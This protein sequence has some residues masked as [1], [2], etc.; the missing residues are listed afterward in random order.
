MLTNESISRK[1]IKNG[2][3]LNP[4]FAFSFIWLFLLIIH[5]FNFN[6]K[7]PPATVELTVFSLF[8]SFTSFVIGI[9]YNIHIREK[10][11]GLAVDDRPTFKLMIVSVLIFIAAVIHARSVPIISVLRGNVEA[12]QNFG[13]TTLTPI[14]YCCSVTVIVISAVKFFYGEKNKWKNLLNIGI[15]FLTF[16]LVY[17]RGLIILSGLIVVIIGASKYRFSFKSIVFL[18]VL[19]IIGMLGFNAFGNIRH[20]YSWNNSSYLIEVAG[21]NK[22]YLA[23]SNFSWTIVYVDTPF[24]N[25]AYNMQNEFTDYDFMGLVSQLLPDMVSKRILP[26]YVG[27]IQLAVP[28]LTVSSMFAG[29]YCYFGVIGM[30]I[31]YFE[32]IIVTFIVTRLSKCNRLTFIAVSASMTALLF[33]SFF[34]NTITYSG[35]FMPVIFML[36]Y[37]YFSLR[38][39]QGTVLVNNLGINA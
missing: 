21:F 4:Y 26:D 10:A 39:P 17:S 31:Q 8:I 14:G 27:G 23:L 13:I 16:I 24:G 37:G 32:M 6:T 11:D 12:Y 19:L 18:L 28:S 35:F 5:L 30:Y 36:V 20:G 29:G 7:F 2:A 22:D 38:K 15:G 33:L 3:L 34:V 1:Q 9:F 25:L